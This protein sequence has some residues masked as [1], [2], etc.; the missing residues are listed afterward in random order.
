M[1]LKMSAKLC[2]VNLHVSTLLPLKMRRLIIANGD[3]KISGREPFPC[4]AFSIGMLDDKGQIVGGVVFTGF[5]G[6][7]VVA[8]ANP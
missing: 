8:K 6:V 2:C 3:E 7:V 5:D 4:D 1:H